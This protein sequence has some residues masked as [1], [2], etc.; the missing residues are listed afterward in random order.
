MQQLIEASNFA[1]LGESHLNSVDVYFLR[2]LPHPGNK[3]PS[4]DC[5]ALPGMQ[6]EL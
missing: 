2:D 1:F 4:L 6:G 5:Q 3:P